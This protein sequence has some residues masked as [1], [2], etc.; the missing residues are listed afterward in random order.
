MVTQLAGMEG[1]K[2]GGETRPTVAKSEPK[3]KEQSFLQTPC[4]T[5]RHWPQRLVWHEP[6]W[7]RKEDVA[8]NLLRTIKHLMNL[9][10]HACQDDI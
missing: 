4:G 10:L 5:E 7:E 2:S 1:S 3:E 6:M 9:M 8:K